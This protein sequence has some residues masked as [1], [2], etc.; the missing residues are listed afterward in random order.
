MDNILVFYLI[1]LLSGIFHFLIRAIYEY[2]DLDDIL[3]HAV[4]TLFISTVLYAIVY[5]INLNFLL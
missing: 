2:I 5:A 4:L 1:I 3:P